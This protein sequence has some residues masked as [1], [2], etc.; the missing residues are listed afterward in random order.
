M[1]AQMTAKPIVFTNA[2]LFDGEKYFAR[3]LYSVLVEG[4]RIT[5][6]S[7]GNVEPG[8]N[9]SVVD[10]KGAFLMPGLIDAH[11]HANMPT[12]NIGSL[13]HWPMS[14]LSQHA[15]SFLEGLLEQGFTSTRDAGGADFGLVQAIDEGLILGPRLYIAGKALSQTGGHGDLRGRTDT[16]GCSC[17]QVGVVSQIVDGVDQ[18]RAAV[19][20]QFRQGVNQI[21]IMVS[22]GVLS[23]TDPIWM[24]QFADDE[25]AV[26]VEEARRW[27]SYVMAHAHTSAA[28]RRCARLGV[29]SIEH[30]TMIDRS[31]ADVIAKVGAFVVPTLSIIGGIQASGDALPVEARDKIKYVADAASLAV[32]HC[33]EAGVAIGL[34]SDLIGSW[35]GGEAKELKL[36]SGLM[37][38]LDILKSATSINGELIRPEK[39]LGLIRPGALADMIVVDGNPFDDISIFNDA[40]SFVSLVM[41]DG[42][43]LKDTRERMPLTVGAPAV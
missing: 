27:R 11:T 31:T 3:E 14:R 4:E 10:L 35:Q 43:V 23:P 38:T 8:E 41:K 9:F 12:M 26:A 37:P 25:I 18:V 42:K 1:C 32:K 22:G 15:R 7:A 33:Y 34:G 6:V 5:H 40:R 24:D 30:G 36:R 20:D 16:Y 13:S 17:S 19:R 29:R 21:K 28:A 2:V 39:D